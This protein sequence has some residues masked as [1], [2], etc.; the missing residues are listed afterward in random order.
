MKVNQSKAN[1]REKKLQ[2]DLDITKRRLADSKWEVEYLATQI[3]K[4][5]DEKSKQSQQITAQSAGI[6]NRGKI[7]MPSSNDNTK[8]LK[9]TN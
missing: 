8:S 3:N 2:K 4:L 7:A 6:A 5:R 9:T 1:E